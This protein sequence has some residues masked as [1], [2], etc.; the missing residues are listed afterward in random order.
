MSMERAVR[1]FNRRRPSA[2]PTLFLVTAI[3]SVS[4][5]AMSQSTRTFDKGSLIIPVDNCYQGDV[6]QLTPPKEFAPPPLGNGLLFAGGSACAG[7][8]GSNSVMANGSRRAYG[9]IWLLLKAGVPLYWIIDAGK[10]SVDAPDMTLSSCDGTDAALLVDPSL[11]ASYCGLDALHPV[12][13]SMAASSLGGFPAACQTGGGHPTTG[14]VPLLGSG[15]TASLSYRGG[16]F[17]IDST[18]A[19]LARDVMAWYFAAP[20]A[21]GSGS[22]P[23]ATAPAAGCATE[24]GGQC[25]VSPAPVAPTAL[26]RPYANPWN[27][28]DTGGLPA[29]GNY[30]DPGHHP[31]H[32]SDYTPSSMVPFY[33]AQAFGLDIGAHTTIWPCNDTCLCPYT[34]WDPLNP[35]GFVN[36]WA[37]TIG[38]PFSSATAQNAITYATVNVHQ[39][40]EA[41]QAQVSKAFNS[42]MPPIALAGMGDPVHINTFRFYLEEA[43]LTFGPCGANPAPWFTNASSVG[44]TNPNDGLFGGPA[45]YKDVFFDSVNYPFP[46]NSA[47]PFPYSKQYVTCSEGLNADDVN[48]PQDLTAMTAI[49]SDVNFY[50]AAPF[51][52]GALP[53]YGQVLDLIAPEPLPIQSLLGTNISGIGCG[54]PLYQEL[55]IPHWDAYLCS[56]PTTENCPLAAQSTAAAGQPSGSWGVTA[57]T[58]AMTGSGL[59]WPNCAT[60]TTNALTGYDPYC[61]QLV[62]TF[63]NA[64]QTYVWK[65][66]NL[67]A[68][69]TGVASLE[70]F[71][72]QRLLG[73]VGINQQITH[74]MTEWAGAGAAGPQAALNAFWPSQAFFAGTPP[75]STAGTSEPA[76]GNNLNGDCIKVAATP[77]DGIGIAGQPDGGAVTGDYCGAIPVGAVPAD[78]D[79]A[80]GGG[81]AGIPMAASG[82]AVDWAGDQVQ[83]AGGV[84]PASQTIDLGIDT[85]RNLGT[86]QFNS[87]NPGT[88]QNPMEV[89]GTGPPNSELCGACLWGTSTAAC[90]AIAGQNTC[91]AWG[92]SNC[93]AQCTCLPSAEFPQH[94]IYYAPPASVV[95]ASALAG[96]GSGPSTN[97]A[98]RFLQIGDF[99]FEGIFGFTAS[100]TQGIGNYGGYATTNALPDTLPLI[101]GFPA[102]GA[103]AF[104]Q[105]LDTSGHY[106]YADYWVKNKNSAN[107]GEPGTVVYLGGDSFDG[108]PDGLRMIWSSMLNLGFLPTETELA[109]SSSVA[110]QIP[111]T[112]PV[113]LSTAYHVGGAIPDQY[114]LQGT[115]LEGTMPSQYTPLYTTDLTTGNPSDLANFA[116]PAERGHFRQYDVS[117]DVCLNGTSIVG[118]TFQQDVAGACASAAAAGTNGSNSTSF[119]N[120]GDNG[121]WQFW[122]SSGP[123]P[124][125]AGLDLELTNALYQASP[126]TERV[127]FSHLYGA[128]PNGVGLLPVSLNPINASYGGGT[129]ACALFPNSALCGGGASQNNI[130]CPNGVGTNCIQGPLSCATCVA[131]VAPL[132]SAIPLTDPGC[133]TAASCANSGVGGL[134]YSVFNAGGGCIP[135]LQD[136]CYAAG[137]P[138]VTCLDECWAGCVESCNPVSS[139]PP[140]TCSAGAPL[141]SAQVAACGVNCATNC[142][143]IDPGGNKC[144]VNTALAIADYRQVCG[145][146]LGGIDHS[147][148]VIV[149]QPSSDAITQVE[150]Y[151]KTPTLASAAPLSGLAAGSVVSTACRPTVAYVGAADGMLHAI[152]IDDPPAACNPGTTVQ[153][154]CGQHGQANFKPGQ[155]LWAFVPNQELPLLATNGNCAESLFVDGVP[156]VK[157]VFGDTGDGLGP[158][159]HTILTDTLGQGG[160]HVFALD[161][162]D[163]LLP[164]RAGNPSCH[165]ST[166]S[167]GSIAGARI[168]LWETGDPLDPTEWRPKPLV[169]E[170]QNVGAYQPGGTATASLLYADDYTHEGPGFPAGT[171]VNPGLGAPPRPFNHYMGE[172]AGTFMGQLLGAGGAQ[173]TTYVAAQ[174]DQ[175]DGYGLS[176]SDVFC[177]TAHSCN[178][179][180]WTTAPGQAY[181]STYGPQGEVVYAFDSITG[182]PRLQASK[183]GA[184]TTNTIEHFTGAL[185]HR[186]GG[187]Q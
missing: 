6:A 81:P 60:M 23:E 165:A 105:A 111:L 37:G 103:E 142:N 15:P 136:T 120:L 85:G 96:G 8:P 72:Y 46:T 88:S 114:I 40:Q 59:V 82:L 79:T 150:G 24:P 86:I 65:G 135:L 20:P 101:R 75:L 152:Y 19:A 181:G 127:V 12:T 67:L 108:R 171:F 139:V 69:C 90:P 9:L 92:C 113:T 47:S 29:Y 177:A 176:I 28:V 148:A 14:T 157:E 146:S 112:N 170:G 121:T 143:T 145:P 119:T 180:D 70:D 138:Q 132:A 94:A 80:L 187:I 93:Q 183:S 26:V 160:N 137:T 36:P 64:V 2:F 109:R 84:A 158:R 87:F 76:F 71:T 39:A 30:I 48:N 173:E 83:W 35:N 115:F 95:G 74:F 16:P 22:Q 117:A 185:L 130:A 124:V 178:L 61:P 131:N 179:K 128:L 129:L 49:D 63:L 98:D 159:Y 100:W 53:P 10:T 110:Y 54:A 147:T 52:K 97:L 186:R 73:S 154:P 21:A 34:T 118:T 3:V 25:F 55:W 99:Y 116:F 174:N 32:W 126:V 141:T 31:L 57:S 38:N 91:P 62:Q 5:V 77:C 122:D 41:F 17:V 107:N 166:V 149:G 164:L 144:G 78:G 51:L 43:G 134:L 167:Q 44:Q 89:V 1:P 4:G 175:I 161:V 56:G 68:E 18:D 33:P 104:S 163:P 151:L 168:V 182:I 162:T 156:T 172:S 50:S 66:G 133:T 102:T 184:F 11:P 7:A 123:D 140:L 45:G 42:P 153:D 27:Y 13:P 106:I 125:S 58:T 169:A 155:E